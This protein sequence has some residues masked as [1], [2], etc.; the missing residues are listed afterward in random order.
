MRNGSVSVLALALCAAGCG[1]SDAPAP[2]PSESVSSGAAPA[3]GPQPSASSAA[4]SPAPTAPA[5]PDVPSKLSA[6]GTEPFWNARID[7]SDLVYTTPEDQTGQS[8]RLTRSDKDGGAEFSGKL[9]ASAIHLEVTRR[10]CSDGM[11]DR[12]YRFTAVLTIGSERRDGCAS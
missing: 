10:A 4:A 8:A 9:G 11:S 6:L 12:T 7:G 3:S 2:L 5:P 1:T